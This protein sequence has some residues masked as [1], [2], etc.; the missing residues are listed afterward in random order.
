M[1]KSNRK[2]RSAR[3][4]HHQEAFEIWCVL[5]Q[6]FESHR[7]LNGR[8]MRKVEVGGLLKKT[9]QCCVANVAKGGLLLSFVLQQYDPCRLS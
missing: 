8:V 2:I 5:K 1:T 4:R 9:K 6:L 3:W 7:V